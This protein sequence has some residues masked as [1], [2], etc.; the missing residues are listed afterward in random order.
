MCC[1]CFKSDGNKQQKKAAVLSTALKLFSL[2][3]LPLVVPKNNTNC[4]IQLNTAYSKPNTGFS[5]C[6]LHL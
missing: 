1:F 5:S 2:M 4:K 6:F 3:R